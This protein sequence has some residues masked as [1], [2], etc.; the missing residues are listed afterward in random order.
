VLNNALSF[1]FVK[2]IFI[3]FKIDSNSSQK[4]WLIGNNAFGSFTFFF[5]LLKIKKSNSYG[6]EKN[7]I[8]IHFCF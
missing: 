6:K 5:D 4:V 1:F 2:N 3:P 7:K 8:E